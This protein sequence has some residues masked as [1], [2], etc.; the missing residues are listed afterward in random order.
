MCDIRYVELHHDDIVKEKLMYMACGHITTAWRHVRLATEGIA[1]ILM[2]IEHEQIHKLNGNDEHG[3]AL[4]NLRR[5][6]PLQK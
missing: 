4:G 5:P 2:T 1:S 6:L 3:E